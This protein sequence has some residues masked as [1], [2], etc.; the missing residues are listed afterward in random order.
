MLFRLTM[1]LVVINSARYN[2]KLNE[3]AT[4]FTH[5]ARYN[6]RNDRV[7]CTYTSNAR[8]RLKPFLPATHS[9]NGNKRWAFPF[10][11]GAHTRTNGAYRQGTVKRNKRL[12]T[13]W[14]SSR[15]VKVK[16]KP[17]G[18]DDERQFPATGTR[19]NL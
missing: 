5:N 11:T 19:G 7:T 1:F 16:V 10:R 3:T 13:T 4:R 12:T 9:A 6:K 17:M 14:K 8:T 18:R 2:I 15:H